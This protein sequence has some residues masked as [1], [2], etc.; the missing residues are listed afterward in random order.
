LSAAAVIGL[1]GSTPAGAPQHSTPPGITVSPVTVE[2]SPDGVTTV[3][4]DSIELTVLPAEQSDAALPDVAPLAATISCELKVHHVH[5]STHVAGTINGVA[6]TKCTGGAMALLSM[7]YSLIRVSPNA[8]QWAADPKTVY[9]V[10]NLQINRWV[11]CSEGPANFRGWAQLTATPPAG[12]RLVTPAVAKTYGAITA[13][14]CGGATPLSTGAVGAAQTLEFT[15][16]RDDS[17]S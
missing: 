8:Q 16:E 12:Y 6:N 15:F 10:A 17:E 5:G 4:S 2:E 13:V 3:T 11:P 14:R 1:A 9:D 7:H